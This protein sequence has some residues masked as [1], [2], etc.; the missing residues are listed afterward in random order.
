MS[1]VRTIRSAKK[2]VLRLLI[3]FIDTS[4]PPETEPQQVAQG[5][6]PPVLDPI[7]GDFQRNIAGARDPEVLTL[8]TSV[9]EK[10]KSHVVSDV[11]RI[12]EAILYLNALYRMITENFED[13]PEHRIRF[14]E[15]LHPSPLEFHLLMHP[16][17][18]GFSS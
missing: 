8:F 15:F 18:L 16:S 10:L 5:F 4:G 17:P 9:V 1:L 3:V 12:M 6:I 13:Y 7:L 2:E 14:Y 11:P